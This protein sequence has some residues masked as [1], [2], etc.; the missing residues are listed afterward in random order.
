MS[1]PQIHVLFI[2]G[3]TGNMF[4]DAVLPADQL[5]KSFELETTLHLREEPWSVVKADPVKAEDFIRAGK[6][7]LTLRKVQMMPVKNILMT[8]PTLENEFPALVGTSSLNDPAI[9]RMHE[10][11]WRQ[12]EFVHQSLR[13][14]IQIE[15]AAIEKIFKEHRGPNGRGFTTLH[16]RKQIP[17]PLPF[18]IM[19]KDIMALLPAPTQQYQGMSEL[20]QMGLVKDGFAFAI[21]ALALYGQQADGQ[22]MRFGIHHLRHD[23]PNDIPALAAAFD[24]ILSRYELYL[25]DWCSTL[26]ITPNSGRALQY[27]DSLL[28]S[29]PP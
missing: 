28:G 13:E 26:V 19:L 11:D 5:P 12:I 17:Q 27:L 3:D 6:L 10:D 16:V 2:D 8:L 21:G 9:F 1:Q 4:A 14:D 25:V 29:S 15:L 22:V 18:P 7:V 23:T 20:R 24:Q